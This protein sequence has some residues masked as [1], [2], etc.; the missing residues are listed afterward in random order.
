MFESQTD[1]HRSTA[2]GPTIPLPNC[3][4]NAEKLL[5][6]PAV[7][8]DRARVAA[9]L[10]DDFF[11]F[12]ASGRIW[13][14]EEILDLLATEDYRRPSSRTLPATASPQDV[15][16]VTYRAVRMTPQKAARCEARLRSSIWIEGPLGNMAHADSTR[17][18]GPSE[19]VRAEK[20]KGR[21][22]SMDVLEFEQIVLLARRALRAFQAADEQNRHTHR[23]QEGQ[24]ICVHRKPM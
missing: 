2:T 22:Y 8:R 3:S 5:L 1:E 16:L 20:S 14:R 10:A 4:A 18:R 19:T 17:E 21:T 6:D 24:E 12:G 9:L 7:R 15:V 13:T 11:E 23:D